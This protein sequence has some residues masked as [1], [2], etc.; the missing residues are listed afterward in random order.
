[1]WA[2][3]VQSS[4]QPVQSEKDTGKGC[5][6]NPL[7]I[8]SAASLIYSCKARERLS[9][10]RPAPSLAQDLYGSRWAPVG[11]ETNPKFTPVLKGAVRQDSERHLAVVA[12]TRHRATLTAELLSKTTHQGVKEEGLTL[13]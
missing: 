13:G 3:Y 4:S 2:Y 7:P 6:C 8:Q 1:M 9:G 11:A 12:T 5:P 10:R